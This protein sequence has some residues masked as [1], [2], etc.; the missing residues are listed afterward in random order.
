MIPL[1]Q[2]RSH[3]CWKWNQSSQTS[4]EER[5][6]SAG[7][8]EPARHRKCF[9]H[10]RGVGITG[11]STLGHNTAAAFV[12]RRKAATLCCVSHGAIPLGRF[13]GK[14]VICVGNSPYSRG[15][16]IIAK[17]DPKISVGK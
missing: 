11:T 2:M 10:R 13:M 14:G 9:S 5:V 1:H 15:D 8:F 17:A 16:A 6:E 4:R 12:P 3:I 7:L